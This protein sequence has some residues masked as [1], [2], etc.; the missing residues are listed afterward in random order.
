MSK[1]RSVL[2]RASTD[3]L[4]PKQL[5]DI[6]DVFDKKKRT[7]SQERTAPGGKPAPDYIRI[8]DLAHA[9]EQLGQKPQDYEIADIEK[10]IRQ[11]QANARKA[12]AAK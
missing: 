4:D 12:A 3:E 8:E 11:E 10:N 2:N 9:I 1:T 6:K 5:K 7:P